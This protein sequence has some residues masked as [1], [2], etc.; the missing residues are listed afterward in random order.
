MITKI[1]VILSAGE[2]VRLDHPN[3]PKPLVK[4]GSKPLIL[5]NIEQMQQAG[6]E[7]IYIVVGHRAEEIQKELVGNPAITASIEYIHQTDASKEGMLSSILALQ[8]VIDGPFF[9]GMADLIIGENPYEL[10]QKQVPSLSEDG[11][12]SLIGTNLSYSVRSGALSRV[13]MQ[14]SLITTL[15]REL[16]SYDGFEVGIY[17][18]ADKSLALLN[19][20]AEPLPQPRRFDEV[21]QKVA[22]Y[23]KLQVVPLEES[24]WFDVNTPAILIRANIFFRSHDQKN[25]Q[26]VRDKGL[27]EPV[28]FSQ[29]SRGKVMTSQICIEKGMVKKLDAFRIIPA[30]SFASP[31]V[32][33]TDSLVDPHYGDKV[34]E[35]LRFGGLNIRKIVVEAGESTKNITEYSRIADEIFAGGIDKRSYLISLGGG[36]INNIAGFLASTLYRGIGLIHIPTSMMA[37]VD[38][39]IDFKQAVNSSHGKNL[40]GSYYPARSILID[41]EVLSTLD[42]RHVVNGISESIKH[43]LV[44][45]H[46]FFDYLMK[47]QGDLHDINFLDYVVR[48]SIE[49]KVPLLNGSVDDDYNEMLP[50]YGHSI[51][52]AIEHLSAYEFLHGESIAIGMCISA[53]IAHILGICNKDVVDAHYAVFQKYELPTVVPTEMSVEDIVATIRYDKH[54]MLGNP[55]MALPQEIGIPWQEKGVYGIPIDYEI[56]ERGIKK[57]KVRNGN[58][59]NETTL[60]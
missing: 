1:G 33:L 57:N 55:E 42:R 27:H 14:G 3:S 60:I 20:L 43:A 56:L 31:H 30:S 35:G 2:G 28:L 21:L 40:F 48:H 16:E 49:L 37:Q 25:T 51:G 29:F 44:Q 19:E 45:D 41:P 24:E 8:S 18:F 10:M 47:Y 15:G 9:L 26:V 17:Y 23:K 11:I 22:S 13:K 4:V 5:W 38:A 32:L 34:L 7:K 46:E 36:V 39:A 58:G 52:H 6:L 54:Y 12:L 59:Q 53:E 50:Q